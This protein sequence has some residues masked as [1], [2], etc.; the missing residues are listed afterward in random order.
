[1]GNI[2]EKIT[3]IKDI[4]ISSEE[5]CKVNAQSCD[6]LDL[7]IDTGE[8]MVSVEYF[9]GGNYWSINLHEITEINK[10]E[11]KYKVVMDS[12]VF[13]LKKINYSN[14]G[15]IE[16]LKYKCDDVFLFIF[17]DE[18]NLILTKSKCDLLDDM[19]ELYDEEAKLTITHNT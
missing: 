17:A 10:D 15:F 3:S 19:G 11:Y 16:A 14:D 13:K 9:K 18:Y 1:M 6:C 5:F 8:S 12:E 7:I 4:Y 2:L